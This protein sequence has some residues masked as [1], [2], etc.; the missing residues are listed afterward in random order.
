MLMR[1]VSAKDKIPNGLLRTAAASGIAVGLATASLGGIGTANG[2]CIGFSGF[3]IDDGSGGCFTTVGSF[4]LGL[5]PNTI[6]TSAGLLTSAIAVG[7]GNE[8][9]EI[10]QATS[11]GF[12][13]FAWAGGPDTLAET[14]GNANLAVVQG[15]N[16]QTVVGA[17]TAFDNVNIGINVG[18]GFDTPVGFTVD[19][20]TNSVGTFGQGNIAV[21]FFGNSVPGGTGCNPTTG[22]EGVEGV[23]TV[24]AGGVSLDPLSV[25]FANAAYNFFGDGNHV[26]VGD[27]GSDFGLGFSVFGDRNDVVVNGPA[28]AGGAL[29]QSDRL[30]EQTGP[31]IEINGVEKPTGTN[32]TVL[33]ARGTQEDVRPSL[34]F[35]PGS[36]VTSNL[37]N[38]T[39]SLRNATS[40]GGS[41]LTSVSNRITT[42]FKNLSDA[43]NNVTQK[44][45]ARPKAGDST[46]EE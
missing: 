29:F 45:T 21:N 2:T 5:G 41:A 11:F 3:N 37:R 31:G 35:R 6:A 43:V 13:S 10:T 32:A 36:K 33:A 23:S 1:R 44:L 8:P 19:H 25:G 18:N 28:A 12:F 4:A 20:F 27:Q 17:G 9:L 15:E 39:S 30:V 24:Q 7:F 34:A 40:S 42:S 22:C 38:V 14:N 26:T 16:A 46:N